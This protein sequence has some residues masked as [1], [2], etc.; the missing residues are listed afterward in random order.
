MFGATAESIA[1]DLME[2]GEVDAAAWMSTCSDDE[3]VRVCSVTDWL[4]QYG[5]TTA[6]GRSMLFSKACAL[7]A[8]YVREGRPR[9]LAQN[10]R[11]KVE[12]LAA[13]VGRGRFPNHQLQVASGLHYGVGDDARAFWT[14]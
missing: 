1:H 8:V 9:D 11:R 10:R 14:N 2:Y 6:S 4:L 5:P 3:L 12:G 13:Q 7:A